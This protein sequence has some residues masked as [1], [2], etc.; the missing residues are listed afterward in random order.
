MY[1][2]VMVDHQFRRLAWVLA[3]TEL[4][5]KGAVVLGIFS[6]YAS[7]KFQMSELFKASGEKHGA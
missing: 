5:L 6:V 1:G 4:R 2:M 3:T 7:N